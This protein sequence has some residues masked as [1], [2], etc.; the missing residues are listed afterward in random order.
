M[1]RRRLVCV[2][3]S[4]REMKEHLAERDEYNSPRSNCGNSPFSQGF[5]TT[6]FRWSREN[7]SV[8]CFAPNLPQPPCGSGE[9]VNRQ[10][11]IRKRMRDDGITKASSA[12]KGQRESHPRQRAR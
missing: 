3:I 8:P 10:Q 11:Q 6:A 2:L 4:L 5:L 9:H 12:I 7:E 1:T